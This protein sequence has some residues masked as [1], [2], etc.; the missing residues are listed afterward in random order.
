MFLRIY[1]IMCV[2]VYGIPRDLKKYS[3]VVEQ[4]NGETECGNECPFG[5]GIRADGKIINGARAT[6]WLNKSIQGSD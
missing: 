5:Y 3:S 6:E 2:D 4:Y 1:K